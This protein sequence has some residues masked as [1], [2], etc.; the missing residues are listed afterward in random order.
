MN[1]N[2]GGLDGIYKFSFTKDSKLTDIKLRNDQ[3]ANWKVKE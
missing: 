3:V 2:Q 1:L